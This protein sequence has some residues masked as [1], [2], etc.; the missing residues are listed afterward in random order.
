MR[1]QIIYTSRT[2]NTERLAEKIFAAVP[3]KEKNVKRI[4]EKTERDDGDLYLVGFWADRGT[5]SAEILDLLSG[6]HHKKVALFGTCGMGNDAEYYR[7]I[8]RN[9]TAFLPEDCEYLGAFFCQGKMPMQVRNRYEAM[10]NPANANKID[11][12]IRNFDEALLHPDRNDY[13]KAEHFVRSLF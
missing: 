9:V 5:A 12:M 7:H 3:V 11:R 4:E 6:L 13:A 2:G 8:E 1:V 10:R